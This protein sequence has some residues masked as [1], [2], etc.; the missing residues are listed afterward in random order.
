MIVL[1]MI[2]QKEQKAMN[3]SVESTDDQTF[4]SMFNASY[5][6][7]TCAYVSSSLDNELKNDCIF[8]QFSNVVDMMS[9]WTM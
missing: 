5:E 1:S 3:W 6:T 8:F 9:S 7:V 4:I 2:I